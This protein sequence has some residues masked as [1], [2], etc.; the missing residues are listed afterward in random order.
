L[1]EIPV[2]NYMCKF[3]S[4]LSKKATSPNIVSTD[5]EIKFISDK[6]GTSYVHELLTH[7]HS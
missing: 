4:G 1:F 7:L 3:A 5:E 2:L 6:L